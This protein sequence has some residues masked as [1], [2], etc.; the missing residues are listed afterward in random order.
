[1]V[2][3]NRLGYLGIGTSD[4]G[5]WRGYATDLLGHEVA[6]ASDDHALYLRMDDH[7]HRLTVHPAEVD[8]ALYVGWEVGDAEAMEALAARVEGAG[9]SVTRATPEEAADRRVLDLVHFVDPHTNLRTELYYGPEIIFTPAYTPSRAIAGFKTGDLG[10]GHV[11]TYV[12]DAEAAARFYADVLGFGV[13]DWIVVP[14]IGRLGCFMHCNARHHSLAFFANPAAPRRIQHVMLEH[15]SLDDV[16][17]AYDI[18][19]ERELVSV[20]LGRHLND[21]MISFYFQNPSGW[22]VELGW[23]AR[24][25]DPDA[26]SVQHYNGLT[27]GGGEWGHDGLLQM[28]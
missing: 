19:R 18:C 20:T 9:V 14:G 1:M 12:P 13:S 5:A 4:A 6:P 7:H 24:E 16:G 2:K 23:G 15:T 26:W 25:I 22:N 27:P 10:L 11:V 3:V 8:D 28:T 17:T 21:R